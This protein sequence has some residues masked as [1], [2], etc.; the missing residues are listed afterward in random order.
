MTIQNPT[1]N[2]DQTVTVGAIASNGRTSFNGL[3]SAYQTITVLALATQTMSSHNPEVTRGYPSYTLAD[4]RTT[5]PVSIN[6]T[7]YVVDFQKFAR[8]NAQ[9]ARTSSDEGG[10]PF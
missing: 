2:F 5:M 7:T 8:Q 10:D 3:L 4:V 9:T 6:G 1:V